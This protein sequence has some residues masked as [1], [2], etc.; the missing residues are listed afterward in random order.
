MSYLK[1]G[2]N[3]ENQGFIDELTE[4]LYDKAGYCNLSE[5]QESG[6]FFV[7]CMGR[8]GNNRYKVE[9]AHIL[10]D[11]I[12]THYEEKIMER[13][14]VS[15]Y[16]GFDPN[17]RKQIVEIAKKQIQEQTR[18]FQG[19]L[20]HTRNRNLILK[21]LT[22]Y[23]EHW[24]DIIVDGFVTFRLKEYAESFQKPVL[25]AV[26]QYSVQKEYDIFLKLLS[27]FADG[28]EPQAEE[29]HIVPQKDGTH[30]LLDEA[31][32]NV[33]A[34][35]FE[36]SVDAIYDVAEGNEA[37]VLISMLLTISPKKIFIH[38]NMYFKQKE[39]YKTILHV[40][41]KRCYQVKD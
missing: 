18:T 21:Q 14:V 36:N 17:E 25:Q 23:F 26:Q 38:Q 3:H 6:F 32:N 31:G 10:T 13:I 16:D 8:D 7:V 20:M 19:R 4:Y 28:Q 34:E 41:D 1:V 9:L 24:N 22:D 33:V 11:L 30:L 37:D 40:F 27:D 15:H 2:V 12:I 5:Y 29:I 39:I 35:Q